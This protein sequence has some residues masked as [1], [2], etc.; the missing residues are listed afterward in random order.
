NSVSTKPSHSR[1]V[2]NIDLVNKPQIWPPPGMME[3]EMKAPPP[4]N[5]RLHGTSIRSPCTVTFMPIACRDL[6]PAT[7]TMGSPYTSLVLVSKNLA[8]TRLAS[9]SMFSV[10]T[11]LV[12]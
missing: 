5:N 3:L 4:V 8:P 6:M 1:T 12:L 9:P 11:T 10:P 7:R 2:H